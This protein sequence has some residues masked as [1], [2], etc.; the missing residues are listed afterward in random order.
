MRAFVVACHPLTESFT[1]AALDQVV[2]GLVA[3]GHE[4]RMRE[5]YR[6]GWEQ[7]PDP[8]RHDDDLAWCDTLVLVYPTWWSGPR[9]C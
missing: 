5:L 3:G 6:D 7:N 1:E 8:G 9:G 4:H 2:G